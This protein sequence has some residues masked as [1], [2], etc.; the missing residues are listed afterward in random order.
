MQGLNKHECIVYANDY[1]LASRILNTDGIEVAKIPF[2]NAFA[3]KLSS[4]QLLHYAKDNA[5]KYITRQSKVF[6]QIDVS[7]KIVGA[8]KFYHNGDYGQEV[9]VA[10]ID[11]G[12]DE[13]IDFVTPHNRIVKFVDIINDKESPY[14]DNGHGTFVASV[15]AGSGISS[16]KRY[17]GIAPKSKIIS[18]KALESNGETGVV[19]ILKAMQWVY[20]NRI[21]YNIRVVCMSFG[22]TPLDKKDPLA[23][24]V[25]VLWNSG[26]V[27]V[28]AAGN[29]GPERE[30][31][32]SPGVSPK[33]ITVGGLKDNRNDVK[34]NAHNFEVAKFSSRGPVRYLYKPDCIAP[35]V[36]ICGAKCGGGYC[37]MSGTSVATPI[38]AGI[39]A[40]LISANPLISPDQVKVR[41]LG[42]CTPI[43]GDRNVE[44]FGYIELI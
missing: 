4:K 1:L 42:N 34:Y 32:K 43:V 9:C 25:E 17:S 7:K 15:L 16:G 38:V 41:L 33:I 39:V 29:S 27:V 8:S 10:I 2:I 3:V 36:D 24:G 23:I 6:A 28:A 19:N 11:T 40:L 13:H 31:I 37:K 21:K 12:I 5:V 44:G 14:D 22:S 30:S 20:D 35:A 26:V 18:I